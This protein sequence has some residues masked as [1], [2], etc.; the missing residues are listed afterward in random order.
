MPK[1][2][3]CHSRIPE[4]GLIERIFSRMPN[5]E[6]LE[7]GN[8][9]LRGNN[10]SFQ[11]LANAIRGKKLKSL[12]L[13]GA[14]ITDK[15]SFQLLCKAF[16]ES[17]IEI[18]KLENMV[19]YNFFQKNLDLLM[20]ILPDFRSLKHLDLQG[21]IM[22]NK[23]QLISILEYTQIEYLDLKNVRLNDHDAVQ[24]ALKIPVTKLRQIDIR[25]NV[26]ETN[27]ANAFR[28]V[29]NANPNIKV[30]L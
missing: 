24:L 22:L 1:L 25:Y 13:T 2:V 4:N 7:I 21:Q 5:L 28:A 23:T 17:A 29:I 14:P 9:I 18:L 3:S 16:K 11:L 30:W 6:S 10:S 19:Y 26:L 27:G 15:N 20:N 8:I 12:L